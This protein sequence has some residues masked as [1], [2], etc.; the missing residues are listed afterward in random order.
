M[1]ES[2]GQRHAQFHELLRCP[3]TRGRLRE[4][5]LVECSRARVLGGADGACDRGLVDETGK[6]FYPI[7][8]GIPV[9]VVERVITLT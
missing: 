8:E 5:S 6:H 3:L 2:D 9:V 4:A 7:E 1:N